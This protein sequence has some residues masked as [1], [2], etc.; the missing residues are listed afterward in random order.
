MTRQQSLNKIATRINKLAKHIDK[1]KHIY[2]TELLGGISNDINDIYDAYDDFDV[3]KKQEFIDKHT[4]TSCEECINKTNVY[5]D[6]CVF[7][8]HFYGCKFERKSKQNE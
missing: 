7:C 3:D 1:D 5:N 4:F 6:E 8:R 2:I